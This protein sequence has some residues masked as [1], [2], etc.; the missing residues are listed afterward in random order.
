LLYVAM[1]RAADRLIVCGSV[2]KNRKMPPGCWYELIRDG[3]EATGQMVDEPGD[4]K[5]LQVRRY[6]KFVPATGM[7]AI[8]AALPAARLPDWL[9]T[10]VTAEAVPAAP[11]RPSSA[12]TSNGGVPAGA[13]ER[14]RALARGTH[15][16]RLMQ[17][18][19]DVAPAQRAEAA[20]RHLARQRD[21][22]D[23]ERTEI[24]RHAVRLLEDLQ[25]DAL[26]LPG[27]KAEISIVGRVDGRNV[28]GQV[29]R[30]VVTDDAVLIVDYKSNRPAPKTLDEARTRHPDYIRQLAL[31]RAVLRQLYPDRNVRAALLWTD[32]PD[33]MEVPRADL[34]AALAILTSS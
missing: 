8:T 13:A 28:S 34:D 15:I 19:P 30:L 29:D 26:F 20:R 24:A 21:L 6:R 33:L 11:L 5:D 14:R 18:L 4:I 7:A 3:L 25:F 32:T 2:G 1:T 22:D 17:S 16:H 31:Y 10:A 23:D 9:T 27:S 12:L